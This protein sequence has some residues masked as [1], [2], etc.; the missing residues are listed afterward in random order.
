VSYN[1][2]IDLGG[3]NITLQSGYRIGDLSIQNKGNQPQ[4]WTPTLTLNGTLYISGDTIIKP[5]HW[6]TLNLNGNTVFVNSTTPQWALNIGA[7][8]GSDDPKLKLRGPGALIAV[9]G[10]YF[11]PGEQLG[12]NESP[13]FVWSVNGTSQLHP[14]G[15]F[16]GA[17][18]GRV[19]VDVDSNVHVTYPTG[20]FG[21]LTI[22]SSI[23]QVFYTI[24]SWEISGV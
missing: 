4:D 5:E 23:W 7:G 3:A 20:G 18:A 16:Y 12:G 1:E 13:I 22:P 8:G 2:T 11:N 14:K 9:G 15:A 24:A 19:E 17:V 10:I 6:M 21:N